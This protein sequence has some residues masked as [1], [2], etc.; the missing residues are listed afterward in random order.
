MSEANE[1]PASRELDALVLARLGWRW[2]RFGEIDAYILES[3]RQYPTWVE[4]PID[5]LPSEEKVHPSFV[6]PSPSTSVA[7]AMWALEKVTQSPECGWK[8]V[9]RGPGEHECLIWTAAGDNGAVEADTLPLAIC[10]AVMGMREVKH[11]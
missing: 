5:F 3:N 7:D 8:L 2:Y 9:R 11:A 1:L 6:T 10:R 4:C